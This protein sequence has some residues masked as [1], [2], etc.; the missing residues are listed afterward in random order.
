[1]SFRKVITKASFENPQSNNQSF[2]RQVSRLKIRKRFAI[3]VDQ[4]LLSIYLP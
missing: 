1:M 4:A 2:Q 3:E